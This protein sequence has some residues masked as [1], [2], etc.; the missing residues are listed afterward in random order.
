[1]SKEAII[2]KILSDAQVKA[3]SFKREQTD[4]ADEIIAKAAEECKSYIYRFDHETDV[5]VEDLLTRSVTVA[6]L[7][8][9][10]LI[11]GARKQV[12]DDVFAR[13]LEKLSSLDKKRRKELLLGMLSN[14]ENGDV[15]TLS[16]NERDIL[17]K[18]DIE[19][20]AKSAKIELTLCD[21]YGNFAGG[22]ILSGGGVDK[23]FTYEV[24][25]EQLRDSL[26]A[27]V[28]KEIFS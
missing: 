10:K 16:Q 11:L 1:M 22:M 5:L 18:E 8:A 14:A 20:Y 24:E 26:E 9:K 28:A 2:D 7:D 15:V 3:E 25:T 6:E 12:L 27:S 21:E 17:K 19:R 13:V 23:N 4:V